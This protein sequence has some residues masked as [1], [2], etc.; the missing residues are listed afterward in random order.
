MLTGM[1]VPAPAAG[2]WVA[3]GAVLGAL[4]L[5]AAGAAFLRLRSSSPPEPAAPP[6]VDGPRDDLADFLAHPP[7]TRG[8]P[9]DDDAGW[10][11]LAM[12]APPLR[13]EEPAPL[14]SGTDPAGTLAG[15]AVG[16]LLLV[17]IAAALAAAHR[18]P[19]AVE[20]APAAS[21]SRPSA[22]PSGG[23]EEGVVARLAFGGV[24]LEEHAVGITAA[25]PELEV[26]V[27]DEGRDV[28]RLRLPAVNCL[29]VA[30]PP[31]PGDP[32][33]RAAR[34][35]YAELTSPAL[36]VE[37][38]GDRLSVSGRFATSR[39][40]PGAAAEP[41]GRSY[42]VA[43]SVV[44]ADDGEAGWRTADGE[45]RWDDQRTGTREDGVPSVLSDEG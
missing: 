41:T 19:A 26:G 18:A 17:G 43:V 36:R 16:A 3:L 7:G 38:D 23:R 33:C 8:A 32:G 44:A 28:A 5:L 31:E 42:E 4:L 40:S 24:V 25:Y 13:R 14:P 9:A 27:D 10:V 34:T 22:A 15:L 37:R 35:E 2:P 1:D 11:P 30:A 20:D 45:L 29:A 21:P 12:P 39:R 6:P